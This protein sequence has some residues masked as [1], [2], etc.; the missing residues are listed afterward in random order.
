MN[1]RVTLDGKPGTSYHL[2]E[3]AQTSHNFQNSL[4]G[5]QS[6]SILSKIF[7]SQRN[8]N[9]IHNKIIREVSNKAGYKI[10]KQSETE[11]QIIMRSIYLQY[12]KNLNCEIEKQIRDLNDKVIDYS[13]DRIVVEISKF[14]EYKDQINKTPLPL[15]HPKN[16]SNAGEKSLTFFKPL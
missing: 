9:L 11:L 15:S 7:F 10:G 1:G 3:N 13:V 16:L 4:K 6:E 8:I 5:I 14:L 2:F 12:G